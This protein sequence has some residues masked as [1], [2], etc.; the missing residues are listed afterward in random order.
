MSQHLQIDQERAG[1]AGDRE[2][3]VVL[4]VA[5]NVVAAAVFVTML[6]VVHWLTA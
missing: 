1:W 6:L 4:A 2:R 5:V 3:S